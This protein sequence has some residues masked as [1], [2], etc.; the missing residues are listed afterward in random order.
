MYKEVKDGCFQ[1]VLGR[2]APA[3]WIH[4]FSSAVWLAMEQGKLRGGVELSALHLSA[5]GTIHFRRKFPDTHSLVVKYLNYSNVVCAT[6]IQSANFWIINLCLRNFKLSP[7]T[8]TFQKWLK[9]TTWHHAIHLKH[10]QIIW[11]FRHHVCHF[12][13]TFLGKNMQVFLFYIE[14]FWW[15]S[16]FALTCHWPKNLIPTKWL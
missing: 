14:T 6:I 8:P 10:Q 1:K 5:S 3:V 15:S 12:Y 13:A 4:D 16:S 11:S 7:P 2:E 9:P